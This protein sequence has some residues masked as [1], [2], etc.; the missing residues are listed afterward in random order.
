MT[1]ALGHPAPVALASL[2]AG[3]AGGHRG[4]R[5]CAHVARCPRCARVCTQLDAVTATLREAPRPSLPTA[6]GC[7]IVAALTTEAARRQAGSVS[8]APIAGPPSVRDGRTDT[9]RHPAGR[10]PL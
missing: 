9:V 8:P 2:R 3:L 5:L 6:A 7:R 10:R 4:R 1:R